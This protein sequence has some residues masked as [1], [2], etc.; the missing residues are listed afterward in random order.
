MTTSNS[1][2]NFIPCTDSRLNQVCDEI[3]VDQI[4]S[5]ETQNII[6]DMLEFAGYEANPGQLTPGKNYRRM[7]GLAAPQVG[8]MKRIV[9]VDTL[10]NPPDIK[11]LKL[12]A[13]INPKIIWKSQ[14]KESYPEACYSVPFH[15]NGVM[16]RSK[17]IVIEAYT[18]KGEFIRKRFEGYTA[19]IF[20]HEIEHLDGKRFPISLKSSKELHIVPSE[21][22]AKIEYRNGKWKIWNNIASQKTFENLQKGIYLPE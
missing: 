4:S 8:V 19:R 5:K 9:I 21:V 15:Y 11:K 6:T 18:K 16:H 13:F 1:Q 2:L 20:Q 3:L 17:A 12:E 22:M 10:I 14:K 7:V